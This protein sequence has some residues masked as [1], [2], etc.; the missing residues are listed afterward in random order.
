M[1][2]YDRILVTMLYVWH[3]Y[4]I[5][6]IVIEGRLVKVLLSENHEKYLIAYEFI[7]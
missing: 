7:I 3:N 6:L 2:A 1:F 4:L 5:Q